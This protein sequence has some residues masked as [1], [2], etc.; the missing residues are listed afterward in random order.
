[1]YPT[2]F[3]HVIWNNANPGAPRF[4]PNPHKMEIYVVNT[5]WIVGACMCIIS[6]FSSVRHSFDFYEEPLVPVKF[7]YKR[8]ISLLVWHMNGIGNLVPSLVLDK[9]NVALVLDLKIRPSFGLILTNLDQN[10]QLTLLS[11]I[12]P[13]HF[14]FQSCFKSFGFGFSS[15]SK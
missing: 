7:F 6:L 14:C 9:T 4:K 8:I 13:C 15:M 1:M 11:P 3:W 2:R 5:L 10:W 12:N